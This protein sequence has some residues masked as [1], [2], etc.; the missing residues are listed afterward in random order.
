MANIPNTGDELQGDTY[1]VID[2]T[3]QAGTTYYYRLV[4]VNN[5]GERQLVDDDGLTTVSITVPE[6]IIELNYHIRLPI[7][8]R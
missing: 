6:L 1:S 5:E 2:E 3:A 7:L 8:T 4:Y